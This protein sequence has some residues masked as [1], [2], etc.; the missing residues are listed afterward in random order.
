MQSAA[1]PQTEP[2]F[3]SDFYF[4]REIPEN[5]AFLETLSWNFFW[6]WNYEAANLFR[7]LDSQLWEKCEQNPR[8]LLRE[9]SE[10]RLWQKAADADYVEK[11]NSTAE[12]FNDYLAAAPNSLG[13][14]T[15]DHP[16]AY[17]C[18]EYGVHNSL[19][20]YSGGLGILA[21]DHLKSASDLKVPLVA[22]GLI[23]RFGYFR[24]KIAHDGWQTE[25]YL[26]SFDNQLAL[27]PV[28]SENGERI[29]IKVHIRGREVFAQAW[30]AHIGRIK[31]YLLDTNVEE[32]AEVDRLITGHLYGGDTE[33]R[34]VQE[35]ILG[36]GGVRLL[37]QLQIEPSVY[38][39][40]EGHSAFLTLEL[41][42]EFLQK[43]SDASFADAIAEV[44][45][46]C[47]FTTHTPVAAGNDT[48]PPEQIEDC[49]DANL[50]SALKI[51]KEEFLALGRTNPDDANEWFGMT[52]LAIRMAR[53]ANGVSAKHG[54]VSRQLWLK[55][56]PEETPVEDVPITHITN[57][58]HAPTW[59]APPFQ[60]LYEKQIGK[61]WQE[62]LKDEAAWRTA[63]EK[64]PDAEI[65]RTHR[66]LKHLLVAFIRHRTFSSETG[67]RETI[68]EHQDTQQ[69]FSP[70]V[71][72][73]GFARRVAAYKRWNLILSDVERLL[74]LVGDAEKPVQFV[75]A[76]KA[77]PQDKTAKA[78]LQKLMTL[79]ASPEWQRRAVFVEDYDQE[80]ARYLVQGVDV[81]LNV[82]IRPMEASG[83]SGQKAAMNGG[84]NFSIL[85]GWWIE[86]YNGT[87]G[88]SIGAAD[89]ADD[90]DEAL[91]DAQDAESLYQ[92]L[93]TEIVPA[94]Y[95]TDEN[96]LPN[97]W[98]R[99]MKDSLTTLTHQFSSDRMVKDYIEKIYLSEN[100]VSDK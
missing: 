41:A 70:D 81:W 63:I 30:L 98:I 13:K 12:K 37:R 8:L 68:N 45:E 48:F 88:F 25:T 32:N 62:I 90:A 59:I 27:F 1:S 58:V 36:I 29:L 82:P 9:I 60:T 71:L 87:N 66:I 3:N 65:W 99:R 80:V 96:G 83:T 22:V 6:S 91:I 52:P 95:Q 40:N 78:L 77:H 19:P 42:R 7:E 39:L 89:D 67:L 31:L 76:G 34:I 4:Q 17:F 84:L 47:V 18:A 16:A 50:I 33:T 69:L 74:K 28:L 2:N 64:I 20:I 79:N 54:A 46:K 23:Y 26:D 85:D 56:F 24:Q 49:F 61:N 97:E 5:L 72:T 75:F 94:Y 14:I 92:T 43:N 51:S 38:H 15:A 55:M 21:G 93:E 57:G 100:L 10:L 35:K 86:G 73:I 11:L 44:R 53:S